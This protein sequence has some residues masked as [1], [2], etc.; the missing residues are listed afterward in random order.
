MN[1]G[2]PLARRDRI[3]TLSCELERRHILG[4]ALELVS[5]NSFRD[6]TVTALMERAGL[7]EE[8]LFDVYHYPAASNHRHA[9]DKLKERVLGYQDR[10]QRGEENLAQE[11]MDFLTS[12]L[13][14]HILKEDMAYS[15]FLVGNGVR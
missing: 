3:T 10:L 9:H 7:D 5:T 14:G 8:G 2:P 6:V 15:E 13:Y 4:C 11:V 12:W 1:C